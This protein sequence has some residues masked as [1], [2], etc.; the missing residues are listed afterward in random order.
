M[1]AVL[2]TMDVACVIFMNENGFYMKSFK[3]F[4]VLVIVY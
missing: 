4:A 3:Q 1:I 2:L